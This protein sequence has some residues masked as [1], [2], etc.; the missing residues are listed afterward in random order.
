MSGKE[1]SLS[2]ALHR[3]M[4]FY[5][6]WWPRWSFSGLD[7]WSTW[8][9]GELF[10]DRERRSGLFRWCIDTQT[11]RKLYRIKA[12]T[13]THV[14]GW[15]KRCIEC[16]PQDVFSF[17][18]YPP[19]IRSNR[20]AERSGT[21]HPAEIGEVVLLLSKVSATN[22][23]SFLSVGRLFLYGNRIRIVYTFGSVLDDLGAYCSQIYGSKE[24]RELL[25]ASEYLYS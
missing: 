5:N 25:N 14:I 19:P 16:L 15:W 24:V 1:A 4:H 2:D 13:S 11:Q 17:H 3:L 18:H 12:A 9:C 10:N 20:I 23:L 7:V 22:S 21:S 8:D 6:P